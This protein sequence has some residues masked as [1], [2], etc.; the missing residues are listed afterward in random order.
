MGL[1]YNETET[2]FIHENIQIPYFALGIAHNSG[3]VWDLKWCPKGGYLINNLNLIRIG[4][5][6]VAFGDG[7]FKIY[8]IPK[9]EQLYNN[10]PII[11]EIKANFE[12]TFDH[13]ISCLEWLINSDNRCMILIGF[14]DGT[15][16]IWNFSNF[17][18]IEEDINFQLPLIQFKAHNQKITGIGWHPNDPNLFITCG[19]DLCFKIWDIRNPFQIIYSNNFQGALPISLDSVFISKKK[20]THIA[21]GMDDNTIRLFGI[22]GFG[23]SLRKLYENTK[24]KNNIWC[25]NSNQDRTIFSFVTGDGKLIIYTLENLNKKMIGKKF[26][27]IEFLEISINNENIIHFSF[28]YKNNIKTIKDNSQIEIKSF[29]NPIL[30]LHSVKFNP[31]KYASRW[32]VTGGKTGLIFLTLIK[33]SILIENIQK[34][35]NQI[36]EFNKTKK[37]KKK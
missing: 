37:Q 5:L 15:I 3:C 20:L 30:A 28:P 24:E 14:Q 10:F 7:N 21:F 4:I 34:N 25:I 23:T 17:D 27:P 11:C 1:L 6:A 12:Y 9:P 22:E 2:K 19:L 26:N 32:I 8:S 29:S 16:S 33:E 36:T 31:N 13:P 18:N 35:K